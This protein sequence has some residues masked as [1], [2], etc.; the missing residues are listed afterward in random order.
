M[1]LSHA[2]A[3]HLPERLAAKASPALIADD[4]QHLAD[5]AESIHQKV[6]DLEDRISAL[7]RAPGG[8]GQAGVQRDTEIHRAARQL[9]VLQRF[10]MDLCLGKIVRADEAEPLYIGRTGLTAPDGRRLL[11]DWRAPAAEPFF[12]ATHATPMGLISRRRYRWTRGHISDY[13]DEVFTS[14]GLD[15]H[16]ALDDQSAFIASLGASRSSR[17]QDVLTTIQAD[18]D[19]IIRAGSHGALVVDGGPGTGKTVVA[20][21]RA[22]RLLYSEPHLS[23]RQNG[24]LFIGP[25]QA[26]RA[27]VDDVLPSLGEDNVQICT[28]RDLVHEGDSAAEEPGPAAVALKSSREF[29]E[30]LEAAVK[31]YEQPPT[32]G[33]H[34]E[35]PWADLWI[36]PEEWHEAFAAPDPGESHN[37]ARAHVW[38]ALMDILLDQVHDDEVP[39][40]RLRR[41]VAQDEDLTQTF[42]KAW[43]LLDPAGVVADLW[44][45]PGYLR[46]CAP[47]LTS[48]EVQLLQRAEPRA[49]TV[50]DLPILD[51][52]RQRIGDPEQVRQERRRQAAFEAEQEQMSLVVDDLIAADRDGNDGEGLVT[53]LR[54][55]D[56]QD[57]LIDQAALP[58]TD[59]DL[60]AG[61]FGHIIVD[62]AQDLTDA[63]W[64]MILRRCP[65]GNLTIVGDRAQARHG[66]NGSWRTRLER[67]GIDTVTLASLTI[68]YR[69]P[70]E[71]MAEAEPVIRSVLPDANVPDSIR[72]A[73]LPVT[74]GV[75][76]DLD[77]ILNDWLAGHAEGSACVIGDPTFTP[78]AR[79]RSMAARDAKGLEFDLVVLVNP[80]AFGHGTAGAVDQYVAMTR[81][82]QQLVVLTS[83]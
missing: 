70:K 35:T 27:Y 15:N 69:T 3:F 82:T 54:Q 47:W 46:M 23:T 1:P 4:E 58:R 22:A 53:M 18:Q 9:Q 68:N 80:E 78:R 51:G 45:V 72:S 61:P 32:R 74:R 20:L 16:A 43:P 75:T 42:A 17:M 30:A 31:F 5:I 7:R 65:S 73:S 66:F 76:D 55:D 48:E 13:W 64:Q 39:G 2:S 8:R 19:A 60:L 83:D 57:P 71:I 21:H 12:A 24:V 38:D 77:A 26:Y 44:S 36:S 62:E 14:R 63:E 41:Y 81:A 6:T 25:T 49:W 28:L 79:V 56:L 40:D 34:V 67:A 59:P 10:D 52:A 11:V 37:E 50:S 29:T 33:M